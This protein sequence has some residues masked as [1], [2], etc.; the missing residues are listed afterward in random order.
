LHHRTTTLTTLTLLTDKI[1]WGGQNNKHTA[2]THT[3][4][5]MFRSDRKTNPKIIDEVQNW[6]KGGIWH[7]IRG[8]ARN[9][10]H[11]HT[12]KFK[13]ETRLSGTRE[14]RGKTIFYS[15]RTFSHSHAQAQP[16]RKIQT[17]QNSAF[18]CVLAQLNKSRPVIFN[19]H[20]GL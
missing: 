19:L 8:K 3:I 20:T 18:L 7:E 6:K 16:K 9:F 11:T 12:H 5:E 1:Q 15:H 13:A 4:G 14:R 10:T 2:H 17:K